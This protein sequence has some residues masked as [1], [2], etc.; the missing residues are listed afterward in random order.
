[1]S[2][3]GSVAACLEALDGGDPGTVPLGGRAVSLFLSTA[4]PDDRGRIKSH[5]TTAAVLPAAD[6]EA[7]LS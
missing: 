3:S 7:V 2:A 6:A 1:M 4:A 5:V